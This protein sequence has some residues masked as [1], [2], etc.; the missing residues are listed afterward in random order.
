MFLGQEGYFCVCDQVPD[1]DLT[2]YPVTFAHPPETT[3]T[4]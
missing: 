3:G 4:H 1:M 2:E